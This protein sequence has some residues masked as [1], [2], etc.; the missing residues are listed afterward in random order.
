[1]E[2]MEKVE[3]L[4]EKAGISYEEAKAVLE[5]AGGDLL[6]AAI[7]LE[8]RGKIRKPETELIQSS[9]I[10][11]EETEDGT[12]RKNAGE[13]AEKRAEQAAKAKGKVKETVKRFIEVIKNNTFCVSRK[14]ETLFLMPVWAL[15]LTLLFAWRAVVPVMVIALFF[16]IRYSF[17]GK[18][19]LTNANEFMD[20]AGAVAEDISEKFKTA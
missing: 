5:E 11:A 12:F 6:E 15:V 1:M 4:R 17:T 7:L 20:K 3:Q 2:I 10:P 13:A 19:D 9:D 14:E 16:G 8:K 18:D